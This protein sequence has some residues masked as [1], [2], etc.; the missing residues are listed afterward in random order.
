MAP[1]GSPQKHKKNLTRK[2]CIVTG[3]A[4][5]FGEAVSRQLAARGA[6]VVLADRDKTKGEKLAAELDTQYGGELDIGF[7]PFVEADLST[8]EGV[9][10]VFDEC[11]KRFATVDIVINNA[12]IGDGDKYFFAED[13][14]T[15]WKTMVDVNVNAV[16]YGTQLAIQEFLASNKAGTVVNTASGAAYIPMANLPVYAATKAAVYHFTRSVGRK[17]P[18]IRVHSVLPGAVTTP[19][20]LSSFSVPG[21]EQ[22]ANSKDTRGSQDILTT[23]DIADAMMYCIESD[24]LQPGAGVVAYPTGIEVIRSDT[25]P[26]HKVKEVRKKE[27]AR[28]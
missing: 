16:I 7:F 2:V 23:D 17:W 18:K 14:S 25:K 6:I 1:A 10:K 4:S 27:Q 19:L 13:A 28:M 20:A 12:G 5:G 9:K 24:D 11:M 21:M 26:V 15:A 22:F 8:F 3:A